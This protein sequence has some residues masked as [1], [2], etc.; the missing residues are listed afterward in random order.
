MVGLS[1]LLLFITSYVVCV[2]CCE[3]EQNSKLHYQRVC[4]NDS[5]LIV[6]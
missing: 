1:F 2:I 6:V 5:V 4:V 3:Y